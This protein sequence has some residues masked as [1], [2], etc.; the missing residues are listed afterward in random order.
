M[1]GVGILVDVTLCTGCERCVVACGTG[2]PAAGHV[3]TSF[4]ATGEG[5]SASR[6][7]AIEQVEGARFARKSCVHCLEPS[8]VAACLVGG[9]KKTAEGPV[10][11][12]AGRCIGCRY[13]MLACPHHVP[14]YEWAERLPYVKKCDMCWP[15]L[16]EGGIPKC[17][18]ACPNG[19]LKFGERQALLAKA[20]ETI[21]AQPARYLPRVWG[22]HEWGGT[23]VLYVSDIDLSQLGFPG[24][25]TPPISA[26]TDPLIEK[27][28]F[29]GAGVA[30]GLWALAGIIARRNKVMALT[31][32]GRD[33]TDSGRGR[34]AGEPADALED[35][36]DE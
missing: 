18:D 13:C 23:S 5:L 12:D 35:P 34:R 24:A 17:V 21:E 4:S 1:A 29:M 2:D 16:K 15:R 26:L 33:T 10:L 19:A 3:R 28:P 31:A 32:A 25:A 22:E 20:R 8:C 36:R 30:F 7:C 9:L 27:T 14:R 11:Y 6:L